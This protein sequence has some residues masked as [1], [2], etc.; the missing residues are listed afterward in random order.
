MEVEPPFTVYAKK[1]EATYTE[2]V[3]ELYEKFLP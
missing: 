2:E 3:R 1:G